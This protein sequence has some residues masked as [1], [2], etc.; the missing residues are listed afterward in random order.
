[1][2]PQADIEILV[3]R[4]DA[5]GPGRVI[6]QVKDPKTQAVARIVMDI[7]VSM[8]IKDLMVDAVD[9][10]RGL[11]PGRIGWSQQNGEGWLRIHDR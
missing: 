7:D 4:P 6:L 10:A 1:M 11:E 3:K 2:S 8:Q 9:L 5:Q